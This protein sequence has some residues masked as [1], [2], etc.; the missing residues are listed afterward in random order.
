MRKTVLCIE[1]NDYPDCQI[2]GNP[3][4]KIHNSKYVY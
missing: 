1:I 2:Q 3:D 4:L